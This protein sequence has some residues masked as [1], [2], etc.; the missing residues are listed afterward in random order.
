MSTSCWKKSL[1]ITFNQFLTI[2]ARP[3]LQSQK[4]RPKVIKFFTNFFLSSRNAFHVGKLWFTVVSAYLVTPLLA[5]FSIPFVCS[6]SLKKLGFNPTAV[7]VI[8][9]FKFSFLFSRAR[10]KKKKR[11]KTQPRQTLI[12]NLWVFMVEWNGVIDILD[13]HR[14]FSPQTRLSAS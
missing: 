10:R 6:V 1:S 4:S 3:P 8:M 13:L 14:H 11:M 7:G 9:H 12:L 5:F 2:S